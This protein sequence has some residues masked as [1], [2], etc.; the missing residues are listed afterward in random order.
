MTKPQPTLARA[1]DHVDRVDQYGPG[2][3]RGGPRVHCRETIGNAWTS[4][5]VHVVHAQPTKL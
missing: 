5:L 4:G 1:V 3:G 2:S